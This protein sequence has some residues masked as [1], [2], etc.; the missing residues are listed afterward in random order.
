MSYSVFVE[1][2]AHTLLS[3]NVWQTVHGYSCAVYSCSC[4]WGCLVEQ[5]ERDM[6]RRMYQFMFRGLSDYVP[7]VWPIMLRGLCQAL[8]CVMRR[9][10]L[11]ILTNQS[12]ECRLHVSNRVYFAT[13]PITPLRPRHTN[14]SQL[15]ILEVVCPATH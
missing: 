3:P 12:P 13:L 5:R 7:G 14:Q 2:C 10:Q 15:S 1:N 8:C 6:F 11:F 4:S 9:G